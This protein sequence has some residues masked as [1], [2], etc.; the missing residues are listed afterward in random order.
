MWQQSADLEKEMRE[1]KSSSHN[2]VALERDLAA[3]RQNH[4]DFMVSYP[5]RKKALEDKIKNAGYAIQN[6]QTDINSDLQVLED[7]SLQRND[8]A[9]TEAALRQVET[10]ETD[11]KQ[12]LSVEFTAHREVL[13]PLL[14]QGQG[15]GG[16]QDG[17]AAQNPQYTGSSQ[18]AQLIPDQVRDTRQTPDKH[19][20]NT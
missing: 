20:T 16:I 13:T 8:R 6:L 17:G 11:I 19:L 14:R 12:D 10:D 9:N 18:I 3:A 15:Q 4:D 5:Q 1:L 7:F 2:T